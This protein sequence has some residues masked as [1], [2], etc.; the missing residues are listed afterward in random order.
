MA[1]HGPFV[2]ASSSDLADVARSGIRARLEGATK[3]ISAARV[4]I[5]GLGS[6]GSQTAEALIRASVEHFT[7]IDPDSVTPENL[8]R[9]VY[10]LADIGL[11][12]TDAL[13]ARL[14]S[15][16]PGVV[17]ESISRD[18]TNVPTQKLVDLICNSDIVI[19]A[20]DD[21][22]AQMEIN[23]R[24]WSLGVP[25]VFGGVYAGGKAGEVIFTV[26]GQ[27][28]CYR[29]AAANRHARTGDTSQMNYGTGQ[30]QA[31]PA[32]GSDIT[33][34]VTASV[35]IAIGLLEM[36]MGSQGHSAGTT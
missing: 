25:A 24:A 29:C 10:Q 3:S 31:E 7:L 18:I 36:E 20:T 13:A 35:K 28:R 26:P 33:H 19:A 11:L 30:L 23:H 9:S 5:V 34:V 2:N 22:K 15:I 4:L 17:I 27:T 21:P 8:S 6:G 32:L 14:R 16:N 1:G 12:K